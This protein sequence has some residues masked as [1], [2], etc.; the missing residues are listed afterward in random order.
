MREERNLKMDRENDGFNGARYGRKN[1][2]IPKV[3]SNLPFLYHET[4]PFLERGSNGLSP[5]LHSQTNS[6]PFSQSTPQF[7][8]LL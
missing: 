6:K 2:G 8:E 1:E 7:W 3:I 5:V 4:L